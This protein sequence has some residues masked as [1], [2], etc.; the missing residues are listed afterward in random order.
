[1][2]KVPDVREVERAFPRVQFAKDVCVSKSSLGMKYIAAKLTSEMHAEIQALNS[3]YDSWYQGQ[4]TTT[5]ADMARELGTSGDQFANCL[6]LG[7]SPD[8][9]GLE[10]GLE[11]KYIVEISKTIGKKRLNEVIA[12][13]L[14]FGQQRFVAGPVMKLAELVA[15][16]NLEFWFVFLM[17]ALGDVQGLTALVELLKRKVAQ[18]HP[19]LIEAMKLSLY[20]WIF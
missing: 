14:A 8:V 2:E 3:T 9:M 15:E 7:W 1:M 10:F 18:E 5:I 11:E 17:M 13:M 19:A 6:D 20:H 4:Q 16:S 12:L